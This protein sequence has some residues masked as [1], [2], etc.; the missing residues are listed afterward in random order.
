MENEVHI[1]RDIIKE[2]VASIKK[3]EIDTDKLSE[4]NKLVASGVQ[5]G[6]VNPGVIADALTSNI[7]LAFETREI[8]GIHSFL[9]TNDQDQVFVLGTSM[10]GFSK[11]YGGEKG[12]MVGNK[13]LVSIAKILH[14]LSIKYERYTAVNVLDNWKRLIDSSLEFVYA[15]DFTATQLAKT[16]VAKSLGMDATAIFKDAIKVEP[17]T[18]L[19]KLTRKEAQKELLEKYVA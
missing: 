17:Q 5:V 3:G 16:P 6:D 8:G 13:I 18:D 12:T 7:L 1:V 2:I 11:K 19:G 10:K 15:T 14:K 9:M 4:L